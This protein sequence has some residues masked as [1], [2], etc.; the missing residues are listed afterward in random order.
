M[1]ESGSRGSVLVIDRDAGTG[2]DNR[3]VAHLA[4]DEPTV[5]AE[6]VARRYAADARGARARAVRSED[7]DSAWGEAGELPAPFEPD[8][9]TIAC[10]PLQTMFRLGLV[11]SSMSIS[12]LRWR[13]FHHGH[14]PSPR[15][16]SLREVIG[17]VESYEPALAI[18]RAALARSASASVCILRQEHARVCS[19]PIV[20]NRGL[21]EAVLRTIAHS[22]VSMSEIA[23]RCGRVKRD[24]RGNVSGETSWLAR[25]IGLLAEGGAAAPTPWIHSDVLA[26]IAREGLV[27]SPREV[28]L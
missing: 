28:E 14:D 18:T 21:R 25:R 17:S 5:N 24:R 23:M 26:L 1:R 27:L 22:D 11:E 2:G 20:L 12:A 7:R 3:L 16:V 19:S 15:V 4:A 9:E 6:L 8:A 10:A 13:C